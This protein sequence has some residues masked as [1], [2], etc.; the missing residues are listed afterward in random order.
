MTASLLSPPEF[1]ARLPDDPQTFASL[2]VDILAAL[3]AGQAVPPATPFLLLTPLGRPLRRRLRGL[4]AREGIR[5]AGRVLY[6]DWPRLSSILYTRQVSEERLRVALAFEQLWH[7]IALDQAAERWDL[8]DPDSYGRLLAIKAALRDRL[9]FVSLR[10]VVPGVTLR[11]PG[12]VVHLQAFHV[13]DPG[14]W[15]HE[16]RLL[17]VLKG[18]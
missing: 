15:E 9:G 2:Q 8:A 12:Q 1:H 3:D 6:P 5:L 4:L 10:L 14:R 18:R 16:S 7:A 13:P 11:S 17:E